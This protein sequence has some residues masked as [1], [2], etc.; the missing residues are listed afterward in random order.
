MKRFFAAI[1]A[2]LLSL[3]FT[4]V[5]PAHAEE[6]PISC[7]SAYLIDYDSGTVMYEK[8][9][10]EHLP[11]ASMC[12]IMTL[13]LCF[14]AVD[15][16][17][18][19][20]NEQVPVSERASGM[21][22]SQVYL[23]ANVT[24]SASDLIKS[25]IVCSANDSSVA[26]AERLAGSEDLFVERMN[27]RAKELGAE[28]TQFSNCTGLPK[29]TQY[30][31]AKD[32]S[33]MLRELLSHEEYYEF[34][35]I[36]NEQFRHPSGRLTD[37]TNTNKLLRNY[38]GCDSGKTGFTNEAGFCL[39]ASAKRGNMRVISVSIGS[40]TSIARFDS[41]RTMFDYAFAN[42][43]NRVLVD[44]EEPLSERVEVRGGKETSVAVKPERNAYLFGKK[45]TSEDVVQEI[46]LE[47]RMRAPITAGDTVGKLIL[48]KDNVEFDCV[49]LVAAENVDR[50]TYW[51]ELKNTAD[52]WAL[53]A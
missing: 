18:L 36:R 29:P 26:M 52:G 45:G 11:I 43:T 7:K 32:V 44:C 49:P 50:S 41:V 13:V 4:N 10:T 23:D 33:M 30:S 3:C 37:I 38:E 42:Y 31:C 19:D 46:V 17:N 15:A 53:G 47:E 24:Y 40:D 34:C 27:E 21:G 1:S 2:A 39:A 20:L 9:P 6:L 28:N 12:K 14:D 22:G 48:Y 51:D 16:G 35:S 5:L 25:I 8:N